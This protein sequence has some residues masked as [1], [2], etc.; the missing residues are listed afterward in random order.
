[1]SYW[2]PASNRVSAPN[3]FSL[4]PGSAV[5]ILIATALMPVFV[6]ASLVPPPLVLPTLSAVSITIGGALG[7]FA[8]CSRAE[9][10]GDG[11]T[12]WDVSGAFVLVGCAAGMLSK[13][14]HVV[15][16]IF[17]LTTMSQ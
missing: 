13:P 14:E 17:G 7:L 3:S 4:N 15:Q 9:R 6:I 2:N 12:S 10:R 11:V 16:L 8:W 1:M 5:A